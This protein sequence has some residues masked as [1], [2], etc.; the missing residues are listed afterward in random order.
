MKKQDDENKDLP[1]PPEN[2]LQH[3]PQIYQIKEKYGRLRVYTTILNSA[4]TARIEQVEKDSMNICE[5]S[6]LV[7]ELHIL[8]NKKQGESCIWMKTLNREYAKT[9]NT[10][11][12]TEFVPYID[13]E[14]CQAK[15][16]QNKA[17]KR[18]SMED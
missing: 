9:M 6:G 2:K 3:V 4:N 10:P 8:V 16:A 1:V 18:Y 15:I 12:N 5:Y 17:A 11:K 13:T 14:M 7:G